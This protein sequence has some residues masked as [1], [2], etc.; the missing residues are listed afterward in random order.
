MRILSRIEGLKTRVLWD[1]DQDLSP[2]P[3]IVPSPSRSGDCRAEA[4][5]SPPDLRDATTCELIRARDVDRLESLHHPEDAAMFRTRAILLAIGLALIASMPAWVSLAQAT[6]DPR[7]SRGGPEGRQDARKAS[8][9]ADS[10]KGQQVR[11][12][13]PNYLI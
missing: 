10:K 13:V 4:L 2:C 5:L 12:I 11:R 3:G 1:Q 7:R 6:R 9:P 8:G